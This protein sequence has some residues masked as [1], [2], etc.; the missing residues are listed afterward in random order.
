[1][2]NLN[3]KIIAVSIFLFI[4]TFLP[5]QNLIAANNNPDNYNNYE[6]CET[7]RYQRCASFYKGANADGLNQCKK[8]ASNYCAGLFPSNPK[9]KVSFEPN[10]ECS[11]GDIF[12]GIQKFF[13]NAIGTISSYIVY[14]ATSLLKMILNK[15]IFGG[16]GYSTSDNYI[17]KEGW[18]I[19]RNVANAA[20][21]LGLIVI[22][23]TIIL[24]REDKAKK[25]LINFIIIALLINFTPVICSFII[26]GFDIIIKS[27]TT[28]GINGA[29]YSESITQAFNLIFK[30]SNLSLQIFYAII[31]FLFSLIL[32]T[33]ILLYCFLFLARTVILWVLVIFS[34]IAFATKV[35]PS[36]KVIKQIFPSIL[37]WDDWWDSFWQWCVIGVPAGLSIYLANMILTKIMTE[38]I[39]SSITGNI[40]DTSILSFLIAYALPFAFLLVGFF[41]SISAGG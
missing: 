29:G 6:E 10:A 37:H 13:L 31:L 35:F 4:A 19:V 24:G 18:G 33:I 26:D 1:M 3:K 38:E 8:S 17:I 14:L 5:F 25:T 2:F 27:F 20:L 28:G 7:N 32:S 12:C 34:P 40:D 22:A 16:L 23:I 41:I 30:E 36:F 21:V 11:W 9:P 39:G 15:D